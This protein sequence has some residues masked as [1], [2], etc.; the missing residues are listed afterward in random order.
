MD[1]KKA[2]ANLFRHKKKIMEIDRS[3]FESNNKSAA[4]QL[5]PDQSGFFISSNFSENVKVNGS[6][7]DQAK[8][9]IRVEAYAFS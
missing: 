2:R 3:A 5:T 6:L 8:N 9:W 4:A 1:R 7:S